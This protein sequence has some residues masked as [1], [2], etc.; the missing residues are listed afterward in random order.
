MKRTI[1]ANVAELVMVENVGTGRDV[2]Y[3]NV[4]DPLVDNNNLKIETATQFIYA[5]G[6]TFPKI[7]ILLMYLNIFVE[8]KVR[9]ETKI[10]IAVVVTHWIVIG[11]IVPLTICQP[12][13]Y[14]WNKSIPG[15]CADTT[16][17]YRWVSV[18][19]IVTDLVILILPISTLYHLQTTRSRN[20]GIA[21]TFLTGELYVLVH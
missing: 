18:L 17:A 7:C 19:N 15:Q 10:A 13:V 3:W 14:K 8:R 5:A 6:A 9:I 4:H 21:L 16:A 12:L 2:Q 11:I 1:L 20:I